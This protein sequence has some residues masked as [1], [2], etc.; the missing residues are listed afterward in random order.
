MS[1][2]NLEV[3][4][5]LREKYNHDKH[6]LVVAHLDREFHA[7]WNVLCLPCDSK[8]MTKTCE[9]KGRAIFL[10]IDDGDGSVTNPTGYAGVF[11]N[12]T[13]ETVQK[14]LR[15]LRENIQAQTKRLEALEKQL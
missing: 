12:F 11:E 1:H 4:T 13:D 2:I 5:V 7:G 9:I 8:G 14:E 10:A 3:G 6:V 15:E